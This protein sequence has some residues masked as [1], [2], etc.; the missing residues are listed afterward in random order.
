M[1]PRQLARTLCAVLILLVLTAVSVRADTPQHRLALVIGNSAYE[2]S[3]L[4]NPVN[5]ATDMANMLK[6]MGFEVLSHLN[7]NQKQ[8][9]N[10]IRTFQGKLTKDS[11]G[12]FFYAGHGMQVGGVNYLVPVGAK[13]SQE[14]DVKY[15]TV[16]AGKVLDAMHTA[17][18]PLNIVVLD[19]CRD[20]PFARSYRSSAKGLAR[21][22]APTGTFIAYATAPGDTAADGEGKNGVFTKYM[23]EYMPTP[24]LE[25]DKVLK[26][27]RVSV[28]RETGKR[29]VPWQSSSLTGDF[30]FKGGA[31]AEGPA[32][33]AVSEEWARI[34]K[35][36]QEIAELKRQIERGQQQAAAK[37]A[38]ASAA[39]AQQAAPAAL[40]PAAAARPPKLMFLLQEDCV[41][42]PVK[43]M[44]MAE[45]E[46][47]A[48]LS[49]KG[50]PL[51]DKSQLEAA[52]QMGQARM[53]LSGNVDAAKQLGT[54]FGA[55]YVL[56]GKAV[57]QE[58]GEIMPG[59]GMKSIQ[60]NIQLKIISSQTGQIVGAT[61]KTA[62]AAHISALNG[63]Q[64]ALAQASR[65]TVDSFV[66]PTLL[67]A[68]Q[69]AGAEGGAVRVFA[70][71]VKDMAVYG[72]LV[73][74]LE[75]TPR[76]T[77][78]S[79][80]RFNKQSG[81]LVLDLLFGGSGED[82]AV[83]VDNKALGGRS[84]IFVQDFGNEQV[85]IRVK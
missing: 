25:V 5:D 23:L 75:K 77:Q 26:K 12:L 79:T 57:I 10:A 83:A 18:N 74:A 40:R 67:A 14:S 27:V 48:K 65:E 17:G 1:S 31:T 47:I 4:K 44:N 30:F 52:N 49:E 32:D 58:L 51:I 36:R 11:V 81:L 22:D 84:K 39:P 20:N 59:T 82:L 6:G 60:T 76:V 46:L 63:A 50:Y 16:D 24:N 35:E 54:M 85:D 71:G 56:V 61:V 28:M 72:A 42:C 19:A 53:A 15:E 80:D 68:A 8:M 73:A 70:T 2:S 7:A 38:P 33:K 3:P 62:A 29:Q 34:E 37:P 69:K 21:M 13:I 41:N 66:V 9:E 55:K 43:G 45:N 64:Q 78:V